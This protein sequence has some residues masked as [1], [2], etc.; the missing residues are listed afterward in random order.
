MSGTFVWG[1]HGQGIAAEPV[2]PSSFVAMA[3]DGWDAP[4]RKVS[5]DSHRSGLA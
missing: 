3:R 4:C 5:L 1:I 2:G